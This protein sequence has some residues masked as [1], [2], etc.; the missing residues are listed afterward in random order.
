M[1]TDLVLVQIITPWSNCSRFLSSNPHP[2]PSPFS[3]LKIWV[4]LIYSFVSFNTL[5]FS[6]LF[7]HSFCP[8][9]KYSWIKLF[10]LM[11]YFS[12]IT[13]DTLTSNRSLCSKHTQSHKDTLK[14]IPS[15]KT[16]VQTIIQHLQHTF[17]I[18]LCLLIAYCYIYKET[19]WWLITSLL[20][21]LDI[22]IGMINKRSAETQCL[23]SRMS[24][25]RLAEFLD[26]PLRLGHPL[27]SLEQ[28]HIQSPLG[29]FPSPVSLQASGS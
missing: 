21:R 2:S 29:A 15:P 19:V 25:Q 22:D 18:C 6:S 13:P 12:S 9:P 23:P 20:I 8:F 14:H 10:I 16:F 26:L 1:V 17:G 24:A 4:T 5:I 27:G 11:N 28:L 7:I 3:F